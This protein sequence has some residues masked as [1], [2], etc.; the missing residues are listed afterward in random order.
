LINLCSEPKSLAQEITMSFETHLFAEN[1]L[2]AV[3]V[4]HGQFA[5][6]LP[7]TITLPAYE[8][9]LDEIHLPLLASPAP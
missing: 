8:D 3:G 7:G 4:P 5:K 9:G 2:P 1:N 6:C